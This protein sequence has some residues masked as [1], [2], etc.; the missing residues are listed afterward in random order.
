MTLQET[1]AAAE[2]P[3]TC[4][5]TL[6]SLYRDLRHVPEWR[7]SKIRKII[8]GNPNIPAMLVPEIAHWHGRELFK[9]PALP[10][11]LLE[12]PNLFERANHT[13]LLRLLSWEETPVFVLNALHEHSDSLV[14]HE[15]HYHVALHGEYPDDSWIDEV[16]DALTHS[17]CESQKHPWMQ[18]W[19]VC[20]LLPTWLKARLA[21]SPTPRQIT[22][23]YVPPLVTEPA[24]TQEELDALLHL[25]L[26]ELITLAQHPGQ[27]PELLR[28]IIEMDVRHLKHSGYHIQ[29]IA[30]RHPNVPQD[31]IR[32]GCAAPSFLHWDKEALAAKVEL[33]SGWGLQVLTKNLVGHQ[34]ADNALCQRALLRKVASGTMTDYDAIPVTHFLGLL[35]ADDATVIPFWEAHLWWH[36]RMAAAL[37]PDTNPELRAFLAKDSHCWVRAAAR[38]AQAD[39]TLWKRFW[40]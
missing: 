5:Q 16:K 36:W 24:P 4:S 17:A 34:E 32:S 20:E 10:L 38:A 9:N 6:L 22:T 27:H 30:K 1:I 33:E 40:E 26:E 18:Y 23:A 7:R 13:N 28:A 21:W 37:H 8:A 2:S 11:L 12:T 29:Q 31:L 39:P 15:A 19:H 25:S 3:K 35:R 14:V